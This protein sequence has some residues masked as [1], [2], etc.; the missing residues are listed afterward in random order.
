MIFFS[1]KTCAD[2]EARGLSVDREHDVPCYFVR[3]GA[4]LAPV[5]VAH[6]RCCRRS[7]SSSSVRHHMTI[8]AASPPNCRP[9]LVTPL[10]S[11]KKR[12]GS[13]S[14]GEPSG[15]EAEGSRTQTG[16]APGAAGATSWAS[17]WFHLGIILGPQRGRSAARSRRSRWRGGKAAAERRRRQQRRRWQMRLKMRR[18]ERRS[19]LADSLSAFS[20]ILH[21]LET[22]PTSRTLLSSC[23][24]RGR[25]R[26]RGSG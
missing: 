20:Q 10:P 1:S 14:E 15:V 21:P 9:T 17:S 12:D 7:A 11:V 6:L 23:S 4:M 24:S 25:H 5:F 13:T 2:R 22:Q 19:P 16:W 18:W 8:A 26:R 3:D